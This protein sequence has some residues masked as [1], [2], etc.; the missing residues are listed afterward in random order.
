MAPP[1]RCFSIRARTISSCDPAITAPRGA[2]RPLEKHSVTVSKSPPICAAGRPLATAAFARRAPSRCS[3]RPSSLPVA[4]ERLELRLRPDGAAGGVVRVLEREDRC[5][6]RVQRIARVDRAADLLGGQSPEL[7]G[8]PARLEPGMGGRTAQLGDHDVSALLDDQLGPADAEDHQR[9][10]VGHRRARQVH[11]LR[12]A[13]ELRCCLLERVDR[14]V[15]ALLLVTDRRGHHRLAHRERR[16]RLGVGAQVDHRGTC[17]LWL[18]APR[19]EPKSPACG[20]PPVA[21]AAHSAPGSAD[22]AAARISRSRREGSAVRPRAGARDARR[23]SRRR[24]GWRRRDRTRP[25]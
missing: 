5:A 1:K 25:R 17:S 2:P 12:L 20:D 18:L 8:K 9:D 24:G 15:L 11:R 4:D 7:P 16:D 13:D 19:A 10:L 3:A 22:D 23:R 21:A 14:R 6:R